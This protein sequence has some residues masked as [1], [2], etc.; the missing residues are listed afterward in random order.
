MNSKKIGVGFAGLAFVSQMLFPVVSFAQTTTTKANF[1]SRIDQIVTSIEQ[2]IAER[3]VKLQAKWQEIDARLLKRVTDRTARLLENRSTRDD[4]REDQ[5]AKL[6]S[7]ATTDV[8]KQAIARFKTTVE[9]AVTARK[10]AVDSALSALQESVKQSIDTRRTAVT[11]VKN[12]FITAKSSAIEKAKA[13]CA[14]GVDP[15]TI[16]ENFRTGMKVAQEKLKTDHQAIAKIK[17]SVESV[18]ETKKQSV[19]KAISDFKAIMEKARTDLK[20]AF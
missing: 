12:E 2:K 14:A 3:D 15:K 18:R 8:Q 11:A 6:E 5:Y 17:T 7:K 19:E 16:R 20:A 10:T 9:S 1:C 4:N 13:D